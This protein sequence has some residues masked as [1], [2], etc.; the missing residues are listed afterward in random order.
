MNSRVFPS[1]ARRLGMTLLI[2]IAMSTVVSLCWA[3]LAARTRAPAILGPSARPF[4]LLSS[5][6]QLQIPGMVNLTHS[7][8]QERHRAWSPNGQV[9]AF[10]SNGVDSDNDGRIDTV[11]AQRSL[12]T[13]RADGSGLAQ[14]PLTTG[15]ASRQATT[16]FTSRAR[17]G[18]GR[19][20]RGTG[21]LLVR[22][23]R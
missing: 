12:F 5:R 14:Y 23:V 22:A 18:M 15:V 8:A 6:T 21:L 4:C 11:T 20:S 17:V 19:R 13:M 16:L 2:T 9:I 7:P 3:R 10:T 1:A